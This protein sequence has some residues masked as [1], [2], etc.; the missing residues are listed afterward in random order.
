MK[1]VPFQGRSGPH[2][3]LN[4]KE[5]FMAVM[6]VIL[7]AV[8]TG[9]YCFLLFYFKSGFRR[10][11]PGPGDETPSVTVVC[12]ARNEEVNL[13]GL[14]RCLSL[15]KYPM[16]K[17]EF[18]LVDDRSSDGTAALLEQFARTHPHA[19]TLRIPV[20][21]KSG[22]PK[23]RAITKA[24]ALASGRI[25]LTTDA[26]CLPGPEWITGIVRCYDAETGMVL[27]YAPYRT[28]GP[29]DTFFHRLLALEYFTM[30]A[31]AAATASMG[32]P[33][34]CNG[35]NLSFRKEAFDG[36]GG[37]GDGEK[38]LSGDDDLFMQRIHSMTD[39][40]IRF[41]PSK[42]S[43]VPNAP[44]RNLRAF[45]RQRIRFS[46]KHLAYPSRMVAALGGV[47]GFYVCLLGLTVAAFFAADLR[48]ACI[49]M[50]LV[51][52]AAEI[53]FLV[54]AQKILEDRKLLKYYA[55]LMPFHLLYIVF[56]PFL[57]RIVQPKWK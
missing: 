10:L 19:R 24:V 16:E 54:R 55:V 39:W 15:Q 28:D 48:A 14:L 34:T 5:K 35:A 53:P 40:K 51:K 52:T 32:H 12:S 44:P 8:F 37:Y 25:I 30:G 50:W 1:K 38:W 43:A 41:A 13:P 27:G 6:T 11:P 20:G 21:E 56:I 46:S 23:K 17:L 29:Y 57:G 49:S 26:D 4:R 2:G 31:V 47:Y 7:C 36:V 22:S 33:T 3:P 42:K 45:I 18:V 9:Y